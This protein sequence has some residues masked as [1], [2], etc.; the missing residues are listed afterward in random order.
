MKQPH[1]FLCWATRT[2]DG[3]EG[4]KKKKDVV[5]GPGLEFDTCDL[6]F[7]ETYAVALLQNRHSEREKKKK[8]SKRARV[9]IW[10]SERKANHSL[11]CC[12]SSTPWQ[13]KNHT[14]KKNKQNGKLHC[15]FVPSLGKCQSDLKS[16]GFVGKWKPACRRGNHT[17]S[18]IN[19][20]GGLFFFFFFFIQNSHAAHWIGYSAQ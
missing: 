1:H 17:S 7:N 15:S 16:D 19:V 12:S 5:G 14:H 18:S 3:G 6:V 10:A 2:R 4:K 9:E 11:P 8:G 20:F 13:D